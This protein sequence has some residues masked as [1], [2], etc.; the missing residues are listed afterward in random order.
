M[1]SIRRRMCVLLSAIAC[2]ITSPGAWAQP[3]PATY[4]LEPAMVALDNPRLLGEVKRVAITQLVVQFIDRQ[5]GSA[6]SG[7]FGGGASAKASVRLA[8]PGAAQFQ[9]IT[10]ALYDEVLGV[11]QAAGLEV[12]P[13]AELAAQ[14]DWAKLKEAGKPSPVEDEKFS[15]YGGWVFSPRDLPVLFDSDD[16]ESFMQSNRDPDPRGE[17]YRSMGSLLGGNSTGARWAEWNLAKAL[18]A[19][20]LKVRVTV[21]LAIV[22]TSGGLLSGGASVKVEP[23]PRLARD[24]TRFTFRRER[25]AARV[26]LDRHLLLPA[27]LLTLETVSKQAD[28]TGGLNRALGLLSSNTAAGEYR[29]NADPQRYEAELLAATRATFARFGAQLQAA[30]KP[31]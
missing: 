28:N 18:D 2:A 14:P 23:L 24:V 3:A 4:T 9:R 22:K 8:G 16:E 13:H 20:L 11:V 7:G 31:S 26:R 10:D 5:D 30:R 6:V 21:P 12:V 19:H 17:Q 27:D 15:G 29:L 1:V 25:A